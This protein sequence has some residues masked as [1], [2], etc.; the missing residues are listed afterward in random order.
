MIRDE[1]FGAFSKAMFSALMIGYVVLDPVLVD[2]FVDAKRIVN[3][4]PASQLQAA[5]LIAGGQF[6]RLLVG[7]RRLYAS[8]QATLVKAIDTHLEGTASRNTSVASAD[9]HVLVR[10]ETVLDE[11]K[12]ISRASDVGL[13]VSGGED[14]FATRPAQSHLRL[15]YAAMPE[16]GIEEAVR[17][18]ARA[19]GR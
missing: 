10:I 15:G 13:N 19:L 4:H 16:V 5:A 12:L 8:R 17:R 7:M 11:R 9:P 14:C 2:R 6:E 18:L 1:K 3:R